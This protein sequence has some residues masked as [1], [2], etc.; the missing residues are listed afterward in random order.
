MQD[1]NTTST[2]LENT[3]DTDF[4]TTTPPQKSAIPLIVGFVLSIVVAA[5][6][7]YYYGKA[8][9][10]IQTQVTSETESKIPATTTE[11]AASASTEKNTEHQLSNLEFTYDT[12]KFTK[13][14]KPYD[15]QNENLAMILLNE[16]TTGKEVFR[17]VD[18][19]QSP[20][21]SE[22]APLSSMIS[23][24]GVETDPLFEPITIGGKKYTFTEETFGE[25]FPTDDEGKCYS[26]GSARTNYLRFV[27]ELVVQV[28][29]IVSE[30]GCTGQKPEVETN[31][32]PERKAEIIKILE[33]LH[34][35]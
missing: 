28:T 9:V 34:F 31:M 10:P 11:P 26:G 24:A 8:Q 7:G 35:K 30:K 12:K 17:I 23:S 5:S 29:E 20:K 27:P 33:T 3:P 19:T 6:V 25:G 13:V 14:Y 21:Y 18:L 1:L 2:A 4:K 32:P 16:T 15:A 22:T